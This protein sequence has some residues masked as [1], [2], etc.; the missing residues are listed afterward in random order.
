VTHSKTPKSGTFLPYLTETLSQT[1]MIS[2]RV[3]D[4]F[5]DLFSR[6]G[7]QFL[8]GKFK[9]CMS[10]SFCLTDT[11]VYVETAELQSPSYLH[12]SRVSVAESVS[13]NSMEKSDGGT[14][15][16]VGQTIIL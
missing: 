4:G 3:S 15:P 12:S 1:K 2:D 8:R 14:A 16:L 5:F 13:V 7:L 6:F 9:Q 10:L 11:L